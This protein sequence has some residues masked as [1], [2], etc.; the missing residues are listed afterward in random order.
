MKNHCTELAFGRMEEVPDRFAVD[1]FEYVLTEQ[2]STCKVVLEAWIAGWPAVAEWKFA[3]TIVMGCHVQVCST[4]LTADN[5]V[6]ASRDIITMTDLEHL[7][8]DVL[9][10]VVSSRARTRFNEFRAASEALANEAG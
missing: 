5:R 2:D 4:R 8:T 10:Q 7:D 1:P 9:P 6:W 3:A